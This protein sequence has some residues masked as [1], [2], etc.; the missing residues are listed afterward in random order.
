MFGYI[1]PFKPDMRFCEYD[2]YKAVYCTLC[3]RLRKNYGVISQMFLSYDFAFL[4]IFYMALHEQCP[5]FQKGHCQFNPAKKCVYCTCKDDCFDDVSAAAVLLLY[6]KIKD[7]CD[8]SKGI[9]KLAAMTALLATKSMKK[10]ASKSY[11][12]MDKIIADMMAGQAALEKAECRSIDEAAHPFAEM[13]SKLCQSVCGLDCTMRIGYLLG[14]WVYLMD[15]ADDLSDDI[16]HGCYNVLIKRHELKKDCDEQKLK[17]A[18]DEI[19]QCI[20]FT[21]QELRVEYER[22]NF[23]HYHEIIGNI[24][25]EGLPKSYEQIKLKRDKKK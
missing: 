3:K 8:D 4:A 18:Y 21:Q 12:Q 24:I 22:L 10:K 23:Y 5:Q 13:L 2:T 17:A 25:Y 20:A 7:N 6:Y 15:A 14:R 9:K 16:K 19:E 11:P 1:K